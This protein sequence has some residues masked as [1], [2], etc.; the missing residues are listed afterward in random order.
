MRTESLNMLFTGQSDGAVLHSI[1]ALHLSD[2]LIPWTSAIYRNL[3]DLRLQFH[4]DPENVS[5][6]QLAG[7]LAASPGLMTLKLEYLDI[8]LEDWNEEKVIRLIR[9]KVLYLSHL[10]KNSLVALESILSLSSCLGTLE[11]GIHH[12]DDGY[13]EDIAQIAQDFLR[14]ARIKTLALT[15][16]LDYDDGA[17]LVLSI[18]RAIPFLE[19]LIL[20]TYGIHDVR[21][22]GETTDEPELEVGTTSRLPNLFLV[23]Q[24]LDLEKLKLIVSAYGVE[25]L[26][27]DRTDWDWSMDKLKTALLK[28]FPRLTCVITDE[29]T[30]FKWP[31]R[32]M[33]D[34]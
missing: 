14:G 18:S 25:T 10:G 15:P 13:S 7:I 34:W 5:T 8:V 26:H 24:E 32:K 22:H 17:Q 31:C 28:A 19:N 1:T 23:A 16:N 11:V 4:H 9:L 27:L 33:F 6:S 30:T 2:V 29:D 20:Y 12:C 21:E 3:V